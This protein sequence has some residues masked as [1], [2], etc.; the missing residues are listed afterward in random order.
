MQYKLY[1]LRKG[2][3]T[4]EEMAKILNISRNS[5]I[6]KEKSKTPFTSD[7]MFIISNLLGKSMEEI[8]LPRCHQLGDKST[9]NNFKEK[10][11]NG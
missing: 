1:A 7:E 3:F 4:Q 5:Y 10:L 6:N 9:K 2:D 11:K 8:F